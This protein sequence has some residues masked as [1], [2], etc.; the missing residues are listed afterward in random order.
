MK[1]RILASLLS[2][3]L[4][5]GL[6]TACS[7]ESEDSGSAVQKEANELTKVTL[8]EVAH[9]IFYAPM[10]VAI[11]EGYFEEEGIELDLVCGFG[12]DKTMTAVISGEADI[13]FMGSE[14]SIYTYNEGAT[15]YVVNFAQLTQ[16]AGNF[17]VAREKMDDFSWE[18]LKGHLVLGGRKGGMPEMVFE[19]ILKENGID[20]E[21]DLEINQ[22]IDFGSTAA[23]FSEGQGDF[24]VEF[25]PGATTLESEGN[26]YVVASLGEDSGYVPYTAFSAK[27][28]YIDENP[29]IIQGFTNAL[30]KGMDY[31]QTH[32]PEEIA[33]VIEPQF[34]ETDLETITTIVTRYYDQDTWKSNLIFEESSFDLLQDILESAGELEKRAP[35]DDLVTTKFAAIAAQ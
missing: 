12:A 8:N 30:Q 3:V 34:P 21:E 10:Y 16:R 1:K 22:S 11:E 32:S 15:D 6:L 7:G 5:V 18:D 33:S 19:Y 25:E 2:A 26:G 29:D 31:V 35:Y 13:G 4:A 24:T 14:A 17:L 20:P 28:S 9:S 27:R 23:A